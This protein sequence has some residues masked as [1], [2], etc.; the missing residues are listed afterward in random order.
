MNPAPVVWVVWYD[1][2]STFCNVDGEP[3]QAPRW[4]VLCIAAY[5]R[6]HGRVV[7]H[8]KDYYVWQGEWLSAD[9]TGLIDYLTRPG[10]DKTVLIGR[11]VPPAHFWRIYQMA[12][13]DPRMPPKSSFDPL[14][15]EAE[16]RQFAIATT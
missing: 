4:G 16:R 2:G 14:E 13:D 6:D 1:D 11:H 10:K 12:V 7:W 15:P 8:A 9:F 5:S 3:H